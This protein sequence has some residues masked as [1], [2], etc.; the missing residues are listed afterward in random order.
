[1]SGVTYGHNYNRPFYYRG[2]EW[3]LSDPCMSY[4]EARLIVDRYLDQRLHNVG[5]KDLLKK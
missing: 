2:I 1:M 3:T 5:Y 4:E